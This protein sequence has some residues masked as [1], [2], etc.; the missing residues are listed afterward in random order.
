MRGDARKSARIQSQA[1]EQDKTRSLGAR[2]GGLA[3]DLD[4]ILETTVRQVAVEAQRAKAR[5][6]ERADVAGVLDDRDEL[7]TQPARTAAH[8]ERRRE[9]RRARGEP[10]RRFVEPVREEHWHVGLAGHDERAA[11]VREYAAER[12]HGAARGVLDEATEHDV[13]AR[14]HVALE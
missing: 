14:V 2:R 8:R 3:L 6:A 9:R 10:A 7:G 12:A 4:R 1:L 13:G 5:V 11:I